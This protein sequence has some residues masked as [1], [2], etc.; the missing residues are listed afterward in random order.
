MH[1]P[2]VAST[3]YEYHDYAGGPDDSCFPRCEKGADA[4]VEDN[5]VEVTEICTF[6]APCVYKHF[7]ALN[8]ESYWTGN[9]F[10]AA[11]GTLAMLTWATYGKSLTPGHCTGNTVHPIDAKHSLEEEHVKSE[12]SDASTSIVS[13]WGVYFM[14][15][16]SEEVSANTERTKLKEIHST[17]TSYCT[18]SYVEAEKEPLFYAYSVHDGPYALIVPLYSSPP[19][20]QH[21]CLRFIAAKCPPSNSSISAP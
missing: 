9:E 4:H 18:G 5:A 20:K 12:G 17:Y 11:V 6:H 21:D 13:C 2:D 1:C 14:Y 3:L 16:L 8:S 7:G 10:P 19:C 15:E